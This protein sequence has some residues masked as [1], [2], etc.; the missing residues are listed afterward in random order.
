M[1]EKKHIEKVMITGASGFIGGHVAECFCKNGIEVSCLVRESSSL[2]YI[3]M[4]PVKFI[5]GSISYLPFLE[6]VFRGMDSVIHLAGKVSDWGDY[7]DFYETNVVGTLNVLKACQANHIQN[8]LITGSIS[9]YGEENS[10]EVKS[11][12]SPYNSHY[13][14]FLDSIFPC[15]MNYYRD[16]KA[17][18]TME[19]IQFANANHINLTVI[20]PVW[21]Y[22]ENEF[23][24]GF[25]EYLKSAKAGTPFLL[26]SK[27]NKFHVVYAGDLARA[28][29]LAFS[30]KLQGINRII[31]G[32]AE[33][34][35]MEHI[36]STFCKSAK[37][38]KPNNLPKTIAYPIGFLLEL[39]YTVFKMKHPPLLTRGR[40]NMFYD[41]IEYSTDKA[42][43]LL[44]FT[45][46][47]CLEE[48]IERTVNWYKSND[49][50]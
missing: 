29:F 27:K 26:G 11:E 46:E 45:N 10:I 4:L 17:L 49:L 15:K 12:D 31:I 40:V 6:N 18:A 32:N 3:E 23:N 19:A 44:N 13:Q 9:S 1:T 47:L 41:S 34:G 21:V 2:T 39:F 20:E 5:N 38:K 48:G 35:K 16:T 42:K 24:T 30:R 37:V 14:Y 22:G 7:E 28:Y 43:K 36:F 33:V 8:V 50:I 25:F